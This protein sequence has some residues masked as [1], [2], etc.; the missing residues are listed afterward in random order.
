MPANAEVSEYSNPSLGDQFPLHVGVTHQILVD[1]STEQFSY[2]DKRHRFFRDIS[3]FQK[4]K[5]FSKNISLPKFLGMISEPLEE[6][7]ALDGFFH[8]KKEQLS[9]LSL[10]NMGNFI[11]D[12]ARASVRQGMDG[13]W[14][15]D[16]SKGEDHKNEVFNNLLSV[17]VEHPLSEVT[18]TEM[19]IEPWEIKDGVWRL[20]PDWGYL[21]EMLWQAIHSEQIPGFEK[22]RNMV[23]LL[24][25]SKLMK[26]R[27]RGDEEQSQTF[28]EFSPHPIITEGAYARGY[29]NNK[30][31][32]FFFDYNPENQKEHVTIRW[33]RATWNDFQKLYNNDLHLEGSFDTDTAI[34]RQSNFFGEKDIQTISDFIDNQNGKVIWSP[35]VVNP[36]ISSTIR[37]YLQQE[38]HP[39]LLRSSKKLLLG[40]DILEDELEMIRVLTYVQNVKIPQELYRATG[41]SSYLGSLSL[42]QIDM[43]DRNRSLQSQYIKDHDLGLVGC[44]VTAGRVSI[45]PSSMGDIIPSSIGQLLFAKEDEMG[46][47]EFKCPGCK[48]V[49]VRPFRQLISTCN[50]EGGCKKPIPRC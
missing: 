3:Y 31:C 16:A 37:N 28:I 14:I 8:L 19:R 12:F 7:I 33:V 5:V 34:M 9:D 24:N 41:D 36:R 22:D 27:K 2:L 38:L 29:R 46:P 35:E 25:Y 42:A 40:E 1:G 4:E 32:I 39:I 43:M 45:I 6:D 13:Q 18:K 49:C 20:K 44:G 21:D 23:N 30:S 10:G 47:L 15:I 26:G 11:A 48:G 17:V 50:A